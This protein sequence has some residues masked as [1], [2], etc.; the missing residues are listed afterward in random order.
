MLHRNIP[1][2]LPLNYVENAQ[3]NDMAAKVSYGSEL[4]IHKIPGTS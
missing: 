1:L 4:Q 2:S 3:S